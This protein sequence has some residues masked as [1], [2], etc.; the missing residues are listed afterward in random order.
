MFIEVSSDDSVEDVLVVVA[1]KLELFKLENIIWIR[2]YF[3]GHE[4]HPK[5]LEREFF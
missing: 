3:K 2:N 4:D 5:K 1:A